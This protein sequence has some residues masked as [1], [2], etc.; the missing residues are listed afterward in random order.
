MQKKPNILYFNTHDTG[1]YIQPYGHPVPA[2]AIQKFA[3]ESV[4]FR[5]APGQTVK[6]AK[7]ESRHWQFAGPEGAIVTEVANVHT[8]SGVR[9]T[10]KVANDFFLN[11]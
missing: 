11:S 7:V 2:P 5:Q 8:N 6:L 3:E 1:R 4:L 9:H 10:D